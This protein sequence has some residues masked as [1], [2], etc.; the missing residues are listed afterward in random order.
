LAA[1]APSAFAIWLIF[2]LID[3]VPVGL[4]AIISRY[5]GE[6]ELDKASETSVKTLQFTI[7][8]SIL[9][10]LIGLS[11]S[12]YILDFVGVSPEVVRWGMFIS[13]YWLAGFQDF[14]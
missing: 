1:I 2:S 5:Y 7:L 13:K 11:I 14:S 9:F 3:I 8:A 4:L 12:R 6:K 10:M